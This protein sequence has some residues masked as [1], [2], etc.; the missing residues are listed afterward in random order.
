[1]DSRSQSRKPNAKQGSIGS[2]MQQEKEDIIR[3]YQP[4]YDTSKKATTLCSSSSYH[5]KRIKKSPQ[6]EKKIM[7]AKTKM[8]KPGVSADFDIQEIIKRLSLK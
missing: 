8:S 2:M 1:M 7:Q 4:F 5:S 3:Q 6:M